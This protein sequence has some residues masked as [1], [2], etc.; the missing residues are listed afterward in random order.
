MYIVHPPAN[1][2]SE[3]SLESFIE[4]TDSSTILIRNQRANP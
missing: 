3:F 1:N 2:Y 4:D